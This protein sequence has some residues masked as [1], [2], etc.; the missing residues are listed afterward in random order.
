MARYFSKAQKQAAEL[1]SGRTGEAD[2]VVPYSQGGET[3]V[4][5]CQILSPT[6]NRKKGAGNF[7]PRE[8][9]EEFFGYWESR[10]KDRPFMLIAIPGSGKT[11]A[12]LKV[13]R[14]WMNAAADRCLIVVVPTDNLRIQWR[15]EATKLG[16]ELQTGEFGIRFKDDFQGGVVTYH[17]VASQT[18]VLKKLCTSRPTMVIFDEVHHCGQDKSFGKAVREVFTDTKEKLL[19]SGTAWRSDGTEIPFVE[20]D[21]DGF[22]EG[23]FCYGYNQALKDGV[24]RHL[25]FDYHKGTIENDVTGEE[26]QLSQDISD[27]EAPERLGRLLD[28]D[29]DF[30]REL[31]RLAHDK[32]MECR[33][34]TDDAAALAVCQNIHRAKKIAAL[35][36]EVTGCTPSIIASDGSNDTV[37]SFRGGAK[38]WLVAVRMVSE[39]TDI[40]RLQV[41]CYLTNTVTELFFRQV[42]GR[43]SRVRDV[44]AGGKQKF[45]EGYVYL[46]A[47][48]RLIAFARDI[49]KLQAQPLL[50]S[51]ENDPRELGD[52]EQGVLELESYSTHHDGTDIVFMKSDGLSPG[53]A[54]HLRQVAKATD[55][56]ETKV[57]EV[58]DCLSI[59][60]DSQTIEAPE[61]P[62]L[63]KE[64]RMSELRK[65]IDRCAKKLAYHLN[66][67]HSEIHGSYK[68]GGRFI[69]Q[70][71][72]TEEQ[73]RSKLDA[74]LTRLN[75]YMRGTQWKD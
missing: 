26:R 57:K 29:G 23:G 19:M 14:D 13:A 28:P 69:K 44:E 47:D 20:Y 60:I 10:P 61:R 64:E 42:V 70:G 66:R 39:G 67:E 2:H 3:S 71:D 11:I 63:S 1:V 56:T 35:I 34:K 49:E 30:A 40:K 33:R 43:V 74:F 41:L 72:M 5:N 9:Q 54:A 50:D 25:V 68:V 21:S 18:Y 48:P 65:K 37:R 52:R 16:I 62:T 46:P 6:A 73:L 12:A 8:W 31:I 55:L 36:K 59:G 53:Q 58:L 75:R 15:E 27:H 17:L 22:A 24:V 45:F 38:E 4:D 32:L 7:I 51:T